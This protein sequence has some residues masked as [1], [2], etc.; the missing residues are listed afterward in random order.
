M[1]VELIQQS[2]FTVRAGTKA[3]H[4]LFHAGEWEGMTKL[5]NADGQSLILNGGDIVKGSPELLAYLADI[6]VGFIQVPETKLPNGLVVPAFKVAQHVSAK[7]EDCNMS[8]D[9]TCKPWTNINFYKAQEVCKEY[10]YGFI[11]ETQWL[12]I[13]WNLATQDC[14]WTGG[15][16]GEGDLFQGIRNSE[17]AKPGNYTLTDSTERRW[18]TLSNGSK[19]CDF[20]GNVFQWVFDDVQGNEKGLIAKAFEAHSPSLTT[21]GYPS[22]T[23]GVGYRPD[24]GSDWSG[25][26][27]IRG[28]CWSSHDNAGVFRLYNNDPDYGGSHIGF[29]C[30][31]P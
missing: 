26:A 12:A 28:G 11:T 25:Y 1:Q 20:N 3:V 27:L 18:M 6:P 29:R 8:L 19:I 5:Q 4:G 15:K 9:G 17:S 7:D 23:K 22:K 14:N 2:A 16:V 31:L 24:A 30:T 13:A 10:E 21:A